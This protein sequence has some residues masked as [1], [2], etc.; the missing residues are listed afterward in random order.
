MR[1][2]TLSETA[3]DVM[4]HY[5]P[6][7][8]HTTTVRFYGLGLLLLIFCENINTG[9]NVRVVDSVAR[10]T[11]HNERIRA[12]QKNVSVQ[13]ISLGAR[14]TQSTIDTREL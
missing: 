4:I 11:Q 14:R 8:S 6:H 13:V 7:T 5:R 12:T 1:M 9:Y 10:C 3:R 2:T